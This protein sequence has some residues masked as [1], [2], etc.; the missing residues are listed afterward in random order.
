MAIACPERFILRIMR[1]AM[2]VGALGLPAVAVPVG[3]G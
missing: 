3:I 1:M 2:T